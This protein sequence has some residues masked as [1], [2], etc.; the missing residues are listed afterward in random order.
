MDWWHSWKETEPTGSN[1]CSNEAG[2]V[3]G[4]SNLLSPFLIF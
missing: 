4:L 1:Y 3:E 2:S